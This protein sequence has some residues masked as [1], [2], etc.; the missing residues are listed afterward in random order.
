M[1]GAFHDAEIIGGPHDGAVI[2]DMTKA[3]I[4]L[5]QIER[6]GVTY[7]LRIKGSSTGWSLLAYDPSVIGLLRLP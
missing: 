3:E 2:D 5:P 4:R 7:T 1:A 6:W